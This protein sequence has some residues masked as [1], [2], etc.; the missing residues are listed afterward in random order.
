MVSRSA[1]NH[2]RSGRQRGKRVISTNNRGRRSRRSTLEAA[3]TCQRVLLPA[4]TPVRAYIRSHPDLGR[5]LPA[6]CA[7]ARNEFGSE[8]ELTLQ[9]V[10][11][12]EINN[13]HLTLYVRLPVYETTILER[14]DRVIENFNDELASA[15]GFL[16]I[17]TDLRPPSDKV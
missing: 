11:D 7:E 3:L 5:L 8:A 10:H 2:K 6:V 1:H 17:T 12:P 13:V 4:L 15:S 16:L 14:M 9:V